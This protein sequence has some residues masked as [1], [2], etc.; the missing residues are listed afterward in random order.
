MSLKSKWFPTVAAV[1]NLI[2]VLKDLFKAEKNNY[3]S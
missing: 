3:E 2:T 1:W